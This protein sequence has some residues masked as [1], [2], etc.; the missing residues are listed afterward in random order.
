VRSV[1]EGKKHSNICITVSGNPKDPG[2]AGNGVFYDFLGMGSPVCDG[3]V[4]HSLAQRVEDQVFER[5]KFALHNRYISH[6]RSPSLLP[7]EQTLAGVMALKH[8]E[9][10]KRKGLKLTI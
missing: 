1:S 10:E 6:W 7:L 3:R 2:R 4:R 9:I 8:E 5:S